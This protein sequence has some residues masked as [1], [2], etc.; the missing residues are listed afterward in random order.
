MADL[1]E[2][3]CSPGLGGVGVNADTDTCTRK[4]AHYYY[5]RMGS[6]GCISRHIDE[7]KQYAKDAR[8][9]GEPE[10][11]LEDVLRELQLS[12]DECDWLQEEEGKRYSEVA[13]LKHRIREYENGMQ[14]EVYNIVYCKCYGTAKESA[15]CP[16][17]R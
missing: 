15:E 10:L 7:A 6:Y 5:C 17:H 4:L 11:V 14:R 2:E 16:V 13:A 3:V 9:A 8:A 1:D 12:W